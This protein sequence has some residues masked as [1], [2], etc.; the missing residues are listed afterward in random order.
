MV[1]FFSGGRKEFSAKLAPMTMCASEI[2]P[3]LALVRST[4][5]N[6]VGDGLFIERP[7]PTSILFFSGTAAMCALF[8]RLAALPLKNRMGCMLRLPPRGFSPASA[9]AYCFRSAKHHKPLSVRRNNSPSDAARE[10]LVG[11]PIELVASNSNLGLAR[12]TNTSPD[13][14]GT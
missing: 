3:E 10:A 14:F 13:W 8:P 2:L 1:R 7:S 11:S 5:R 12:N 6:P 4:L 9:R